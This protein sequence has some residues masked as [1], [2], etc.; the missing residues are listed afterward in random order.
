MNPIFQMVIYR[1]VSD[2]NSRCPACDGRLEVVTS[3]KHGRRRCER[4]GA[5]ATPRRATSGSTAGAH[6]GGAV[7]GT[8]LFRWP[9]L[10]R[11]RAR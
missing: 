7:R 2:L 1:V 8:R 6:T 10:R 4:C 3:G 5:D 9:S 11:G